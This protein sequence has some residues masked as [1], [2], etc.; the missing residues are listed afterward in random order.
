[1]LLIICKVV[2]L[3]AK[4]SRQLGWFYFVPV[5]LASE[6]AAKFS[7]WDQPLLKLQTARPQT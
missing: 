1:M 2:V 6:T 5:E 3:E 7:Y 4:V